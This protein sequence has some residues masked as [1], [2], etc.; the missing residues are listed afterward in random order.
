[1]AVAMTGGDVVL[2]GARADLL[3]TALDVICPDRRRDHADQ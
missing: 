2:E 1:M 3:Q